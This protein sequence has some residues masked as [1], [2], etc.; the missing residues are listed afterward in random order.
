MVRNDELLV[1]SLPLSY[2]KSS[3]LL[4]NLTFPNLLLYM[5]GLPILPSEGAVSALVAGAAWLE[6]LLQIGLLKKQ[7]IF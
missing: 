4:A 2:L 1:K 3:I 6:I 5:E 7:G